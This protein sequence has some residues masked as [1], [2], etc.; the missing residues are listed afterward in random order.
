MGNEDSDEE[1]GGGYFVP[2][3]VQKGLALLKVT[4]A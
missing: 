1:E 4:G 2:L 3:V